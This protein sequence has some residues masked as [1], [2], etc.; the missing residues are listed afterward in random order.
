MMAGS[1]KHVSLSPFLT[2]VENF[3]E[4]LKEYKT[5]KGSIQLPLNKPLPKDLI[6]QMVQLRKED[7]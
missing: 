3:S 7:L 4:E 5:G 6:I 2:T 1:T